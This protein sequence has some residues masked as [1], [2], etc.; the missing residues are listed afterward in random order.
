MTDEAVEVRAA[1]VGDAAALRALRLEALQRHPEAFGAD[2]DQ[3]AAQPESY[4]AERIAA[5]YADNNLRTF[6]AATERELVGMLT[7]GREQLPK[8]RHGATIWGVYVRAEWRGRGLGA[9]L[10]T[11]AVEWAR[12]EGAQVVKLAVVTTNTA[13]IRCY[14][15][16]GFSVYGVE[17]RVLLEDGVMYDELLMARVV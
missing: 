17:P 7:V 3:T 1:V 15:R 8:M 12:A 9:R 11:R 6:V 10:V 13:A 2:Y 16:C 14:A 5:G 4:W